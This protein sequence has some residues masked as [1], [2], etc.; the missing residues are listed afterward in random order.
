MAKAQKGNSDIY[1][2]VRSVR[3]GLLWV[4]PAYLGRLAAVS[5]FELTFIQRRLMFC[6]KIWQT[7]LQA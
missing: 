5:M 2:A 4:H 6:M 1:A 3:D 7:V